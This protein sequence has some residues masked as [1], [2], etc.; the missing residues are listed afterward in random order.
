MEALGFRSIRLVHCALHDS[1]PFL[2]LNVGGGFDGVERVLD[3][4]EEL[5]HARKRAPAVGGIGPQ[6]SFEAP[7]FRTADLEVEAH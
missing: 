5:E 7:V 3:H 4:L 6:L 2:G 1:I